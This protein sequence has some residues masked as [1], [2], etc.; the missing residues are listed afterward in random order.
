VALG[1]EARADSHPPARQQLQQFLNQPWTCKPH[2]GPGG[3]RSAHLLWAPAGASSFYAAKEGP[4]SRADAHDSTRHRPSHASHQVLPS[5]A[6]WFEC[7]SAVPF[8]THIFR[9]VFNAVSQSRCSYFDLVH[10][11]SG[12]CA[13]M[14]GVNKFTLRMIW[15]GNLICTLPFQR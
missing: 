5:H 9:L 12:A 11:T 8:R 1:R 4:K 3:R 15:K 7:Q 10:E 14:H 6:R 2:A 13:V